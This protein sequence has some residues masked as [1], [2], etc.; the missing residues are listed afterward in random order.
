R[1]LRGVAPQHR[2]Q[3]GGVVVHLAAAEDLSVA[4]HEVHD[5]TAVEVPHDLGDADCEEGLVPVDH[6]RLRS[7]IEL[8]CAA[9]LGG[10]EH[11]ELPGGQA[12]FLRPEAG[13]HGG[14]FQGGGDV[15][16]GGQEHRNARAGGEAGRGDLRGHAAGA[17]ATTIAGCDTREVVAAAHLGNELRVRL[18]R[19]AVVETVDVGEQDEGVREEQ[20]GED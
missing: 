20:V 11:P 4:V 13:A 5:V 12:I 6:G 19:V 17:E 10:V 1:K 14:A 16:G 8:Q 2:D 9:G 7:V 15:L 3:V 18:V